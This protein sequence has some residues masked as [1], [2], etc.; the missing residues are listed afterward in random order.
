MARYTPYD[1]PGV[2]LTDGDTVGVTDSSPNGSNPF[3]DGLNGYEISDTDGNFILEFDPLIITSP[4]ISIDYFIS[5]TGYEGDG[6]ANASGSDR[7]RIYVK[8]LNDLIE[9]DLLNT[10]GSDINDLEI[11]GAWN[12]AS[13][14]LENSPNSN[15]QLIIEARN[16]SA[17]EAFFFDNIIIEGILGVSNHANTEFILYPNPAK[18]IITILSQHSGAI[19]TKVYTILGEKVID[20]TI[21]EN[22]LDISNLQTGAYLL[23]ITQGNKVS[24]KKLIVRK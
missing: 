17:A 16:N 2:G 1:I 8:N 14:S 20:A 23:K 22:K 19:N 18:S 6:T 21:D 13:I 11:E 9:Y 3:P 24:T 5:E 4:T 10:T 12:T 15:I 7:L